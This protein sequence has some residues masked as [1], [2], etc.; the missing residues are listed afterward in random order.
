MSGSPPSPPQVAALLNLAATVLPADP[1]RLSRVAFWD[2]D[3]RTRHGRAPEGPAPDGRAPEAPERPA[4]LA[5]LPAEEL[6]VALPSAEGPVAVVTVPA[7]VLPVAAAVPVLTRARAARA[8]APAAGYWGAAAVLALQ[9][10]ARG[11]LL[12]GVTTG[13]HDAWR[14]GPLEPAD[15]ERLRELAE[16]MPPHAHAVP[17]PE[18]DAAGE[19]LLPRPAE[20]LRAFLDAV[21]DGLPRTPAAALAAGSPAFAAREPVRVAERRTWASEVA[22][23]QDAGVGLSLRVELQAPPESGDGRFRAVLQAHSLADP[24][25]VVDAA[26]LWSD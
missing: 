1:P 7:T 23:G 13:D 14:L 10:A 22:A 19:P 3:D 2:P 24:A 4:E 6:T 11:R 9:L 5:G 26:A 25:V 17:L 16:A 20:L 8:A 21:A 12:P 15:A 18:P